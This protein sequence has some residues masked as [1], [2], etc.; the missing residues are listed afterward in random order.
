MGREARIVLGLNSGTSADGVD[1]VAC[2]ISGRGLQM[3]VRVIGHLSRR[4]PAAL[5]LR[6]LA[7]MAPADT[8]TE[9]ICRL[10]TEVGRAFARTA[11]AA[12][13]RFGLPRVDLVGS[14]GQTICHLP[15]KGGPSRGTRRRRAAAS[16]PLRPAGS[17]QIGDAAII[18]ASLG[19]PMVSGFWQA[20]LAAGGQGAPLVPWTDYVLFR[21]VRRSRVVQNLGG[22]ANLTWLPAGCD[23]EDVIAFDT[24]PANMLIDGLVSHFSKGE[25][26][27]DKGGRLARRGTIRE[28]L[29]GAMLDH[30]YL[31]EVPPKSCGR[32]AFG[33]AWMGTLL[34]RFARR[35][36]AAED[37]IATATR[38]SALTIAG[39]YAVF[40]GREYPVVDEVILCGGGAKNKTL[41]EEIVAVVTLAGRLTVDRTGWKPVPRDLVPVPQASGP[42]AQ[43]PAPL[44]RVRFSTTSDYGIG[45]QAKEGVSFAMLAAARVDGV[46]ANLPRVT[47]A[48]RRVVLGQV[49]NLEGNA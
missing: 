18:A 4:Y 15:P 17:L 40:L 20:D 3:R 14:H 46:P 24:G 13:D 41:V 29:L 30:P 16:M 38:F 22:I 11:M 39:A 37:W 19:A 6:L 42:A 5:R 47:G 31:C 23:V 9:E 35:R 12:V 36:F 27:C 28:D 34:R 21:D 25:R 33:A 45:V 26:T 32:E 7:A 44:A 1:A 49:C 8:R 48:S 43:T 10:H 2:E